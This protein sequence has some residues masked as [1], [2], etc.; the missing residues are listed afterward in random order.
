MLPTRR[1][2]FSICCVKRRA[3]SFNHMLRGD[4]PVHHFPR[5]RSHI[6]LRV[7]VVTDVEGVVLRPRAVV[8]G[9]GVVAGYTRVSNQEHVYEK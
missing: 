9:K 6:L 7:E 1:T 8:V 2:R 5:C 3:T 4:K